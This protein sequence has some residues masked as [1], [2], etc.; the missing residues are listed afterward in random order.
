MPQPLAHMNRN[1]KKKNAEKLLMEVLNVGSDNQ[2]LLSLL[3]EITK[4]VKEI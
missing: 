3:R 4:N 2:I 1:L